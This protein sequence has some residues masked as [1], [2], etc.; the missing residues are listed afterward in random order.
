[1]TVTHR[2]QIHKRGIRRALSLNICPPRPHPPMSNTKLRVVKME[3]TNHQVMQLPMLNGLG[4]PLDELKAHCT[5]TSPVTFHM[6]PEP[7]P[8]I[9]SCERVVDETNNRTNTLGSREAGPLASL[10]D[11]QHNSLDMVDQ[12]EGSTFFFRCQRTP[13]T[14]APEVV[15]DA[16][17]S[18]DLA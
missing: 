6:S 17:A 3:P 11:S 2:A 16:G 15:V 14:V 12:S 10:G 8:L 4:I 9:F 5:P 18:I 7:S 1:M 13:L